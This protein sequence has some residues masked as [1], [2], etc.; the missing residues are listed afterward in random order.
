MRF[1]LRFVLILLMVYPSIVF[2]TWDLNMP[3]G[4]TNTSQDIYGLHM[5][6]FYICVA[7]AVVVFGVMFWS[8]FHHRKSK[9]AQA[10]QFHGSVLVEVIWTII[11]LVILVAMAIPATK[12]LVDMYDSTESDIDIQITG[13]QWKWHYK[14]IG[15]DIDFFSSLSTPQDEIHN[16]TAKNPNYLLEVD[17]VLVLPINKK[18]R[19]LF[20]SN[21]VIH[22]WWVPDLAIKKDAIPGFINE[23]WTRINNPGIYRGQ[24][25]ELCGMHHGFMPVVVQAVTELEYESWLQEQKSAK[26]AET[27]SAQKQWSMDELMTTGATVYQKNCAACHQANGQGMPPVFPALSGSAIA[28]GDVAA[29]IDIVVNGRQGTAMAAYGKQ[30]SVVEIAAVITYERNSWDNKTGDIVTPAEIQVA[31]DN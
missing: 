30:L 1:I 21:D 22:A 28:Q 23:S 18:I 4:V 24:C 2:A 8:I 10:A 25:A 16:K 3:I 26:L 27:A 5:T 6:I 17:N 29:H 20:T 12:T 31:I 19:F 15:E 7:I 13:Y 14:Y 11:P 9:G